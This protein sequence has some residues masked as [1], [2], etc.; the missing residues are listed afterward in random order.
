VSEA[1]PIQLVVR[2]ASGLHAR[3]AALFVRT[4]GQFAADVR[5]RSVTRDAG[6]VN[7][8]SIL[9]IMTLG[10][11]AGHEIEI[12]ASGSDAEEALAGLRTLV[13]SGIGEPLAA[14]GA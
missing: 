6:P 7:A 8:K 1:G 10:V 14:E 9:A 4:A 5:V 3:P 2:N 11:S 13:E 12:T